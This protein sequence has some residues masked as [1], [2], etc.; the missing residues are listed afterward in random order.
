[1]D[2]DQEGGLL[3]EA[4]MQEGGLLA[5]VERARDAVLSEIRELQRDPFSRLLGR[6]MDAVPT[7]TQL[8]RWAQEHPDRLISSIG[9]IAK[10]AGYQEKM[11]VNKNIH[12]L[13]S[14]MSDAELLDEIKRAEARIV[15]ITPAGEPQPER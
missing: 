15:D 7:D 1:M 8:R 10:L 13:I 11:E 9:T 14:H 12:L 5:D 3:A 2:D 4:D 6:L